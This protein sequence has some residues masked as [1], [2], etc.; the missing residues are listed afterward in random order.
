MGMTGTV[1][2]L[3]KRGA[4]LNARNNYRMTALMC[5]A[6][7][8]SMEPLQLLITAR[9]DPFLRDNRGFTAEDYARQ[10]GHREAAKLLREVTRP[11]EGAPS[12]IE[13]YLNGK[14]SK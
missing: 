2:C 10:L 6:Q 7:A 8:G 9:A 14:P 13:N 1:R 12:Q 11:P 5:A 3:I 4:D